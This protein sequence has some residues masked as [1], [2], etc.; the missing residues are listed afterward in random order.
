[1][2][3][4]ISE[5]PVA[6]EFQSGDVLPIVQGGST[7]QLD[8]DGSWTFASVNIAGGNITGVLDVESKGA[9]SKTD[10]DDVA[11]T[12]TGAGAAESS[13]DFFVEVNGVVIKVD[14]GTS[15]SMPSPLTAGT[16]YAIWVSPAGALEADASFTVA[17]T[18]NGRLVGGFHYAPGSNA[19]GT[20]G[21]NTTDQI[22]EYSFWD[23]KFRPAC[24]DPRGMTLVADHFWSDI[25]L[26]NT[27]PDTNGTSS[28]GKTI[29][30]GS[31]APKIP[32]AFGGNGVTT[33]GSLTW[34]EAQE[35][36]GAYGKKCPTYAEFMQ[37]AY[38]VTEETSRG[39]DPGTT[40]IDAPRTS[41]WGVIQATGNLV[42]W[43]RDVI[44]DG[45]GTGAWRDIAEG[46]GEV[47]TYNDDLRGGRFG[48][49]WDTTTRAGSRSSVWSAS[50]S[51]SRDFI[52]AR[53]VC[54]HLI[55]E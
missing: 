36:L 34:F 49:D 40:Q 53:G 55:L 26:L 35:V 54:D 18:T 1:M 50:V 22:N 25:Y 45:T 47:Y 20:S 16:D 17:P 6:T 33:Y 48:G 41:R 43:G 44:A 10:K 5:L 11:W 23:L 9:F 52:S 31:S 32:A 7:K 51:V 13:Q 42:V 8:S 15:I 29:A 28:L 37:L 2:T 19:T 14:S 38:G 12:K 39:T 4:K 46:R 24:P 27:D 3:V 30:D 21:G